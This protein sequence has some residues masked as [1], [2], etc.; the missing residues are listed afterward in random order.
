MIVVITMEMEIF[1]NLFKIKY[2]KLME[3]L[4]NDPNINISMDDKVNVFI[5]MEPIFTKMCV[6]K[7][8]EYIKTVGEQKSQLEFISCV[9]NLAAHYKWFFTK[10][11]IDSRIYL[12]FPSFSMEEPKNRT[13][14]PE[15]RRYYQYKFIENSDNGPIS[16]MIQNSIPFIQLILEYIQGVYFIDSNNIENS[17]VPYVITELTESKQ[18]NFIVSTSLYDFQYVNY[19]YSILVPKQDDSELLNTMNIMSF[20]YYIN[21]IIPQNIVSSAFLPFILALT[22]SKNRNIYNIRGMGIKNT[23]KVIQTAL[24]R[25]LISSKTTNINF[26]IDIIKPSFR[27]EVLSNFYCTDIKSQHSMLSYK[28]IHDIESQITD[29]FDNIALKK[30]ND[31]YFKYYPIQLIE[32]TATPSGRPNVQF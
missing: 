18:H 16:K 25:G 20:V 5:N 32:I 19:G 30:I 13:F 7:V 10:N 14:N 26:L 24:N 11:K 31:R 3:L 17:V 29:K 1:F 8:N 22:G 9:I 15:Y 28:D 27:N 2:V 6:P 23:I 21:K 12:Y 4:R